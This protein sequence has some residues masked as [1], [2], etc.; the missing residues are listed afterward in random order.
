MNQH[1]K[2]VLAK[3]TDDELAKAIDDQ[4]ERLGG[5]DQMIEGFWEWAS[6]LLGR[7]LNGNESKPTRE[8]MEKILYEQH[9]L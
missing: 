3:L 1:A 9:Q 6:E 2:E 4:C 7:E 8:E 5:P